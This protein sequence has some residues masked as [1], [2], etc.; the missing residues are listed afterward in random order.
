M[1]WR[2]GIL[3]FGCCAIFGCDEDPARRVKIIARPV[4]S[5][6]AKPPR[7]DLSAPI[8]QWRPNLCPPPPEP[9]RGAGTFVAKGACNFEHH[10]T[11]DC[12]A[13][14]DDFIFSTSRPARQG[15]TLIIYVNVEGYHGPNNYDYAQMLVT[16]QDFKGWYRWRSFTLSVTVGEGEKFVNLQPTRLDPLLT[17]GA[18][19]INIAGKLWCRPSA[20][21]NVKEL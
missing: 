1:T 18:T 9:K 20:D 6:K 8:P 4:A 19:E 15:A 13:L 3:V 2:G 17:A 12:T 16:V 14:G 11:V 10:G 7:Q 21:K 5:M